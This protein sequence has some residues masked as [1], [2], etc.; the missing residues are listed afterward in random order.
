MRIEGFLL[1]PARVIRTVALLV[2][3]G[4]L[5]QLVDAQT[6]VQLTALG[7]GIGSRLT[8][9]VTQA[10]INRM[11][12][13]A[14]KG[15]VTYIDLATVYQFTADPLWKRVIVWKKDT[16]T[17]SFTNE[18]GPGGGLS[19]PVGVDISARRKFYLA[20]RGN[21]WILYATFDPAVGNL[22]NPAEFRGWLFHMPYLHEPVDVAWDG[23][24]NPLTTDFIYVLDRQNSVVSY[25]NLN[26]TPSEYP[27]WAYGAIGTGTGQ[28]RD[29]TSVC[30][31]KTPSSSGGTQFTGNFYVVDNG[32]KR[33]VW[34]N[35]GTSGAVWQTVA[36]LAN[37]DPVDCAVDHF[38][39]VYI[40]DR[41]NHRIHKFTSGLTWLD[42]YGSYGVGASMNTFK[43]PHAISVP[44]GLKVVNSQSVWYCEGRVLT[45]E[46]WGDQSGAVEH[47]LGMD[48]AVTAQPQTS[49]FGD[50][51]FSYRTTDHGYHTVNVVNS[52]GNY[53]RT[54]PPVGILPPGT[55]TQYWDG[56]L[57]NGTPAPTGNYW[58]Q[59][60]AASAYSCGGQSWCQKGLSTQTF[61]H[62]AGGGC[63]GPCSPGDAADSLSVPTKLVLRQRVIGS[64]QPLTRIAGSMSAQLETPEQPTGSLSEG[65]RR[66]GIR[67]LL[68]GVPR[69]AGSSSVSVRVYSLAGR[70]IR[71]LVNDPLQPGF[72]ELGWDGL[73]DRGQE[74]A[75]GVYFALL[76]AS[77]S[78]AMQRLIIR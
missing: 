14:T 59:V 16:W 57:N 5:Q 53:V 23:Q 78:R 11:V 52:S 71:T 46:E 41:A 61:F 56:F 67:G 68:I 40:A 39:N 54:I 27:N 74:V 36:S 60:T 48:G 42:S 22:V 29:P 20:D 51:W 4:G 10:R 50:A 12:F 35:R 24:T 70:L 19:D 34:L 64:A 7:D 31:G 66:Y 76:A 33:L 55:R 58:I 45:A 44:C 49:Q 17:H 38:G 6:F 65:V 37:W 3:A 2:C 73:D 63:G 69:G 32:N 1:R 26:S 43:F 21:G 25:W 77:G 28:F 15:K 9:A 47:Y 8:R 13:G 72:Y 62:Q 75:P 18:A 30:V